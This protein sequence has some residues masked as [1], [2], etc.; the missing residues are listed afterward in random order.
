MA[1]VRT[2]LSVITLNIYESN[3]PIERHGA[4]DWIFLKRIQLYVICKRLTLALRTQK[5]ETK[6]MKRDILC[7]C[8]RKKAGWLCLYMF[9]SDKIVFKLKTVTRDKIII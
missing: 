4:A 1:L 3:F 7:K 5:A 9:I 6:Y 2:C 8:N